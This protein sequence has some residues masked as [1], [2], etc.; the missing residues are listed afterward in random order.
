MV[1]QECADGTN[2][3]TIVPIYFFVCVLCLAHVCVCECTSIPSWLWAYLLVVAFACSLLTRVDLCSL[4]YALCASLCMWMCVCVYTCIGV[5]RD[6]GAAGQCGKVLYAV[7]SIILAREALCV[8]APLNT[9]QGQTLSPVL[10]TIACRLLCNTHL[11][12]N[13]PK[14]TWPSSSCDIQ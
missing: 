11:N 12:T 6:G 1:K 9:L 2:V 8:E 5:C 10:L 14:S 13:T 7:I 3:Q 4:P